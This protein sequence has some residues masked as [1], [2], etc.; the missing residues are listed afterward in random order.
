MNQAFSPSLISLSLF[1][2]LLI[3]PETTENMK[4]I[5]AFRPLHEHKLYATFNKCEIWL[6]MVAFLGYVVLKDKISVD[7]TKIVAVLKWERLENVT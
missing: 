3:I 1:S 6:E 7:P 2:Q 4:E 5:L